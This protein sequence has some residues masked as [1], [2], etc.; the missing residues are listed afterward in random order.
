M[1]RILV[2]LLLLWSGFASAVGV[3]AGPYGVHLTTDPVVVPVGKA[4]LVVSLTDSSGNPVVGAQMRAL[5]QMPGM[6]MG[7]REETAEAG[8][9]PGTYRIPAAFAMAGA[10]DVKIE[11]AGPLGNATA[12]IPI[13]TGQS[14]AP[15]EASRISLTFLGWL[16]LG[17]GLVAFVSYRMRRTG[18]RVD[19]R[20][21]LRGP[22]LVAL[23]FLAVL[24]GGSVFVVSHFR[25]PGAMTPVEAQVMQMSTP[26]PEGVTPVLLATVESR[27]FAPS[28]RY[29]GQAV[30]FVEQE[31]YPRV[32]GTIVWMP[33]YV[34]QRVRK[35]QVLARLD[36]SQLL[37][38]VN[39]K[40]AMVRSARSGVG[41]AQADYRQ[42]VAAVNEA[43]AEAGQH[44]GMVQEFESNL[45]AAKDG[46]DA[47][48]AMVASAQA[49][50]AN[51]RAVV[52]S[53]QADQSYWTA[54]LKRETS[55]FAAGAVS[56]DEFDKER[57]D[58]AKSTAALRQASQG[59]AGARAK[60]LAARAQQRQAEA[61][62]TAAQRK[63]V[64]AQSELMS[65]HAHIRTAQ[66]AA[67]S[68]KKRIG[69][70]AAD[71]DVAEAGLQGAA[72]TAGYAEIRAESN[73]VITQRLISPGVLVTPGQAILKVSQIQP[74]R[75]QA[76]VPESDLGRI[77]VGAAVQ[78][79]HGDRDEKP[80]RTTVTSVSPA[81]D[82]VARTG[83]VEAVLPNSD[84]SF[85]PGQFVSMDIST[86]RSR[87]ALVVPASAVKT[88]IVP[89]ESGTISTNQSH[90]V[91]LA[92]PVAGQADHFTVT[93]VK[94]QVGA[95]SGDVVAINSGLSAGQQ[96]VTA[97]S[98]YL[99]PGQ[100]V[101]AASSAPLTAS[102]SPTVEITEH[103]FV[104]ATVT[105]K[106]GQPATVTF[107]RKTDNTCAKSV[108]FPALKLTKPLPLNIP[109]LIQVPAQ[110]AGELNYICG[111]RMLRGKVVI[112]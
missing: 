11:I 24:V 22:V 106:A 78:V 85:L 83:V 68:A 40:V 60:L 20:P 8:M 28:V 100:T 72:A 82:P 110:E 98:E 3:V 30:G 44:Q 109:V 14:T 94:V 76:N 51:E 39:E 53:A 29:S 74:I 107:I 93:S 89:V 91:W 13:A 49:D 73:G 45:S 9:P 63:V 62:V 42:A 4:T 43:E 46:L 80:I 54:E 32:T 69:Q 58:A 92:S 16:A 81:L 26:A 79:R 50:A 25:R 1:N 18:Q 52:S 64:Q 41:A 112:Q 36:T 38:Q 61:G 71:V 105:I 87:S 17:L 34:G 21:A 10:Y 31:V 15:G 86:E 77:Q 101:T 95:A 48:K 7:E 97:G 102:T 35:G 90:Y 99:Q 47:S 33:F 55:L 65:H 96:V 27:T 57:A 23:A 12:T 67:E 88:E 84:R 103:G 19:V 56:R 104:P 2:L 111:M 66:A 5:A 37:P 75:V 6:P 59:L 108:M 70:A